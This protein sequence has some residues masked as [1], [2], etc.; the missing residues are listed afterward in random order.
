[1]ISEQVPHEQ[2]N[3][4]GKDKG[5]KKGKADKVVAAPVEAQA[6]KTE[7]TPK[8]VKAEKSAAKVGGSKAA[9]R[10]AEKEY[11]YA[12]YAGKPPSDL[13]KRMADFVIAKCGIEFSSKKEE[14][15]FRDGLRLGVALR[16]QFQASPENQAARAEAAAKPK[17]AKEPKAK[18]AKKGAVLAEVVT[19]DP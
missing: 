17:P 11:D 16:I 9:A 5:A 2:E 4:M 7:K 10:M 14:A 6:P 13:Q 3:E 1:M 18:A 19:V 15:A 8:V 12:S